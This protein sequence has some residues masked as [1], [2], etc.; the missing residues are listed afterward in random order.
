MGFLATR[1]ETVVLTEL[2]S[3]VAVFCRER[4]SVKDRAAVLE[5]LAVACWMVFST[6]VDAVRIGGA[7]LGSVVSA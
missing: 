5:M 4:A 1:S 2:V 3:P 6:A 7:V